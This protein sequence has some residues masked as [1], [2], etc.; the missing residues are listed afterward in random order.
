MAPATSL[1]TAAQL[2]EDS[3]AD[4]HDMEVFSL[5]R[6]RCMLLLL[7]CMLYLVIQLSILRG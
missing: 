3:T 4:E 5:C 7:L 6:A 2:P 1:R